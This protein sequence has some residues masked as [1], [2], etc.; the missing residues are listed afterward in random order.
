MPEWVIR[1]M[2]PW[3]VESAA[4]VIRQGLTDD[5]RDILEFRADL[6][7]GAMCYAALLA[8]K[9]IG[10][11]TV[12][13]SFSASGIWEMG[14]TVVIESYRG[15]GIGAALIAASEDYAM[16]QGASMMILSSGECDYHAK[17]GYS[18]AAT[19]REDTLM[20]KLLGPTAPTPDDS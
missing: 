3:E 14:W 12:S 19:S 15:K 13:R 17:R 9:I 16:S 4:D 18:V 20:M 2:Y 5:E 11:T 8:G 6:G 1:P 7:R 10:V